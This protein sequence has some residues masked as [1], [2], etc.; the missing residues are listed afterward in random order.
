MSHDRTTSNEPLPQ[1]DASDADRYFSFGEQR[2]AAPSF[3]G[4]APRENFLRGLIES[5]QTGEDSFQQSLRPLSMSDYIGQE[6]LKENL[7]IAISA[8]KRRGDTL[9][10]VLLYGPPG[11]GK[12]TM[13]AVIAAELGV[14]FKATSGPVLERPGDLAAILS[15]LADGDVLFIDEIHRLP[16]V[17]EEILYPALEDFQIDIIVGQGAA[18]RSVKLQLKPFTL[19]GATTRTGLLTAPLRDRFGM[20]ER[21]EFYEHSALTDIVVRSAKILKV[22]LDPDGA[23]VIATRSR[24]TPRI[25][26]RL[27]KRAR[28][29]ASER[30]DSIITRAVA[31]A[32]LTRLDIDAEGLDRMDRALLSTIIDKFQGGPVGL[33]TLGAALNE[34]RTTIEDV[35]EPYL[36]QRGYLQRTPRGREATPLAYRYLN[37][38]PNPNSALQSTLFQE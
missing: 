29:F 3:L 2:T 4:D 34:D 13:A 18:A 5:G 11:L 10:H 8:A 36:I 26:N 20:I 1:D 17:V 21:M 32:A 35:Y 38:T 9:D 15:S 6:R 16:R 24:G 31:D 30:A 23:V 33:D 27:L 37:R 28:D 22:E 19:V 25:A 12:T 14:G 7:A